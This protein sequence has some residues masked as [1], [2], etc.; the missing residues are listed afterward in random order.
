MPP[1]IEEQAAEMWLI[2]ARNGLVGATLPV[3]VWHEPESRKH[4]GKN[5]AYMKRSAERR[6]RAMEEVLKQ[7]ATLQEVEAWLGQRRA[8]S[9]RDDGIRCY[10]CASAE[11]LASILDSSPGNAWVEG[12]YP[13]CMVVWMWWDGG[14]RRG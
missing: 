9:E 2:A 5:W 1:T 12:I 6:R 10:N 4:S 14:T 8:G 13:R 7:G 3:V 11:E